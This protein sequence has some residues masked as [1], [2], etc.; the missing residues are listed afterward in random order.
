MTSVDYLLSSAVDQCSPNPCQSGGACI[1]E[2]GSCIEYTC[3]CPDCYLGD[4]CQIGKYCI[5]GNGGK[6]GID[7]E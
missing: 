7:T 2:P 4:L 1:P 6:R 3:Q 5:I